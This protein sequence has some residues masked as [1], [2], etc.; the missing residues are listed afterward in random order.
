MSGIVLGA[1]NL[2]GQDLN[3]LGLN[4]N[5]QEIDGVGNTNLN[6]CKWIEHRWI[7]VGDNGLIITGML[8]DWKIGDS[9]V[10]ANL[11]YIDWA[12]QDIVVVGDNGAILT[13]TDGITWTSR[14]SGVNDNLS[15]AE[16]NRNK[17]VVI[18]DGGTILTSPDRVTWA[19]QTSNTTQRLN[20]IHEA[21][22]LYIVVGNNGTILKSLNGFDW[23]DVPT[24]TNANLL[25]INRGEYHEALILAAVGDGGTILQSKDEGET[26]EL[27]SGPTDANLRAIVRTNIQWHIT[28][29]TGAVITSRSFKT[30]DK[31]QIPMTEA[32]LNDICP[33]HA[34]MMLLVGDDGFVA[35]STSLLVNIP[36]FEAD[37]APSYY[38]EAG[39]FQYL[40][41]ITGSYIVLC[42]SGGVPMSPNPNPG[43]HRDFCGH[44]G[45]VSGS[46]VVNMVNLLA[47][48]TYDIHAG[49]IMS[50]SIFFRTLQDRI[51]ALPPRTTPGGGGAGGV[52]AVGRGG[53]HINNSNRITL[54]S[55]TYK[56]ISFLFESITTFVVGSVGSGISGGSGDFRGGDGP[57]NVAFFGGGGAT[58][59]S[60]CGGGGGRNDVFNTAAHGGQARMPHALFAGN[61]RRLGVGGAGQGSG[62]PH[63]PQPTNGFVMVFPFLR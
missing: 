28:T 13:S 32:P 20:C 38:F 56:I 4:W 55:T 31:L 44:D 5:L 29:E 52:N 62:R 9:G 6:S 54:E 50:S 16:W 25:S 61:T 3:R 14:S 49:G 30:F 17:W 8:G 39:Q 18:G 2:F 33:S 27:I 40:A 15:S 22:D 11:N 47:G 58:T 42:I 36:T 19:R 10:S 60:G 24:P 57:G 51:E 46:I 12:G 59:V 43:G 48:T 37:M 45:G 35:L 63:A 21:D 23:V 26:W 34:T 1:E 53:G 41:P 7:I